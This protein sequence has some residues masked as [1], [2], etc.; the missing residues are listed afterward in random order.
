MLDTIILKIPK[1]NY[2]ITDYSKF[3]TTKQAMENFSV[4]FGSFKNNPTAEDKK[5]GIYKPCLT[6]FRRGV[7]LDLQIQFSAPKLLFNN[8]LDELEQDDFDRVVKTLIERLADMGVRAWTKSIENAEVLSFHPSKNI[9][10]TG[11]YTASFAIRELAKIDISKKFDVDFKNYRNNGQALQFYTNSH[12]IVLYDKINDLNKAKDRAIDKDQTAQ[13]LDIFEFIKEKQLRLEIL[14]LE[15]RLSKKRKMNEVL[16][17]VGYSPNPLF[18]NILKKDL[19]Q[20]IVNLYWDKFFSDNKFLFS[21]NNDSQ[22]ILQKIFMLDPKIKNTKAYKLVGLYMLCKAEQGMRGF[23]QIVDSR[24]K[25]KVND[26]E[27]AKRD[28]NKFEDKIFT[29]PS[30]GFLK[31]I[32]RELKEFK[33]FKI[34]H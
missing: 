16:E 8:N 18:K 32:K 12:A 1:N 17:K 31:D 2:W 15:I 11:G 34:I 25:Y 27:V 4:G 22:E 23:R 14:R 30:W 10:L 28:F 3:N 7:G 29:K 6:I 24:W 9:P 20:K 26:W 33:P 5:R 21:A 19:C 13:Q